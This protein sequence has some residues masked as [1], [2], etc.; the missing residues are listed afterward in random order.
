MSQ[1]ANAGRRGEND[2]ETEI[3]LMNYG[4]AQM[5]KSYRAGVSTK[6]VIEDCINA[7]G[8]PKGNMDTWTDV[9][10][11]IG[12]TVRGDVSKALDQLGTR[13]GF[14]WNLNDMRF[15]IYDKNRGQMKTYGLVLTPDNSSTPERQDDRFKGRVKTIQKASKKK[16]IKG[17]KAVSVEK[18]NSG[19]LIKTKL[20]PFL[21]CGSTIYLKDFGIS[22][23]SGEKYVYKLRHVGNNTGVD[24]YSEIYCC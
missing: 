14:Y 11:P 19:F 23:A 17:L 21:Q 5:F 6:T 24:A 1:D 15:N 3:T 16:G 22:D 10:L 20:V 8:L 12:F 9:N 18:I 2:L 13:L 4:F 7:F